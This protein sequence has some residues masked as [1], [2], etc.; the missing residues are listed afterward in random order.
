VANDSSGRQYPVLAERTCQQQVNARPGGTCA[1]ELLQVKKSRVTEAFSRATAS[2]RTGW[3]DCFRRAIRLNPNYAEALN[4]LAR[5]L[6]TGA[7]DKLRDGAEAVRLAERA[8][9]LT[10]YGQPWFVGTLAAAYAEAGRFPEA[11]ATAEKA[12]Q[13]ATGAGMTAVAAKVREMLAL[14]RAGQPYHEPAP[15]GQPP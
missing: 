1:G 4:N 13:L 7:D 5:V 9:V 11:V 2:G 10:Q 15:T 8:C 14:Y 6:A 3:P 12:E